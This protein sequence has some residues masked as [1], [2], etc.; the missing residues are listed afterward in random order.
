[1]GRPALHKQRPREPEH[2]TRSS[3][4]DVDENKRVA[5]RLAQRKFRR[6]R[7]DYVAHLEHELAL[8][9]RGVDE[10]LLHRRQEVAQ[11]HEDKA[12]LRE[13]LQQVAACLGRVCGVTVSIGDE[14]LIIPPPPPAP[15]A[16]TLGVD[17]NPDPAPQDQQTAAG[18]DDDSPYGEEQGHEAPLSDVITA[19]GS[20]TTIG[21]LDNNGNTETKET[22]PSQ[23]DD[24]DTDMLRM[25]L[26]NSEPQLLLSNESGDGIEDITLVIGSALMA[27]RSDDEGLMQSSGFTK[28]GI[29]QGN[30]LHQGDVLV[31]SEDLIVLYNTL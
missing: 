29:I 4:A 26:E 17:G 25:Y 15:P 12:G 28:L 20:P 27:S 14:C 8:C 24:G 3:A 18:T 10:E 16:P 22:C 5:N 21:D 13:M 30:P 23:G 9:R 6:Q 1:M 19:R 11:L 31:S 7:K 2:T